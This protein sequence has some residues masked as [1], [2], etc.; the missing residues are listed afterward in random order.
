MESASNAGA[1]SSNTQRRI[2]AKEFNSKLSTKIECY[3]FLTR[4][5]KAYLPPYDTNSIYFM[6]DIM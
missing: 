3:Q 6:K 1:A 2:T 5:V 4:H